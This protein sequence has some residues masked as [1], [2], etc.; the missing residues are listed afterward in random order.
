MQYLRKAF[1]LGCRWMERPAILLWAGL[2]AGLVQGIP[3]HALI[4]ETSPDGVWE[5]VSHRTLPN[6]SLLTK[7]IEPLQFTPFELNSSALEG[8]LARAPMEFTKGPSDGAI[9]YVPMPEGGYSR[10]SIFESNIL[11]PAV[12]A[13][14][15]DAKTY[16]GQGLD[17]PTATIS[18][19]L[20]VFGFRAMILSANG[21]VFIDP[22]RYGDTKRYMSYHKS[23]MPIP[24]DDFRCGVSGEPF[25]YKSLQKA[26]PSG[27]TLRTYRFVFTITGEYFQ[28][29]GD[30]ASAEAQTITTFNRVNGIRSEE[31]RVGKECRSRWSPY[32]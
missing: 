25:D 16:S 2:I 6:H 27:S 15:P 26:L 13:L 14:A 32:H 9:L 31:R 4:G 20:T 21:A 7:R 1:S 30:L 24:A 23:D 3:A 28:H 19:D 11:G 29:W 12:R 10:F 22:Y 18:L 8:V 5:E 17:D